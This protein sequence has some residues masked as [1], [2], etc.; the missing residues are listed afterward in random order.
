MKKLL[1]LLSLFLISM[2]ITA[3]NSPTSRS[4]AQQKLNAFAK[5]ENAEAIRIVRKEIIKIRVLLD[6]I[7]YMEK[8]GLAELEKMKQETAIYLY[9]EAEK[10]LAQAANEQQKQDVIQKRKKSLSDLKIGMARKAQDIRNLCQPERRKIIANIKDLEN[11]LNTFVARTKNYQ[12]PWNEQKAYANV[13]KEKIEDII[14]LRDRASEIHIIIDSAEVVKFNMF[15]ELEDYRTQELIKLEKNVKQDLAKVHSISERIAIIKNW[16]DDFAMLNKIVDEG[17][18]EFKDEITQGLDDAKKEEQNA[19]TKAQRLEKQVGIKMNGRR[20]SYH[21]QYIAESQR[22]Q[23]PT[24]TRQP[25][26]EKAQRQAVQKRRSQAQNTARTNNKNRS[27]YTANTRIPRKPIPQ[28]KFS[29]SDPCAAENKE[30]DGLPWD[31]KPL[32]PIEMPRGVSPT[33]PKPLPGIEELSKFDYNAAVSLA[34]ENMRLLYGPME[35]KDAKAFQANWAPLFD[36]PN[37]EI[38]DYLNKLNPMATQFLA[39]RQSYFETLSGI[40]M[41]TLDAGIAV[42]LKDKEVF[43]EIMSNVS[44]DSHRL[45]SLNAA[46][47]QLA[48]RISI[49][50]NPPNP[51]EARCEARRRYNKFFKQKNTI[52]SNRCYIV[53][54]A[55]EGKTFKSELPHRYVEYY[56]HIIIPKKGIDQMVRFYLVNGVLTNYTSKKANEA[57]ITSKGNLEMDFGES[58]L[59]TLL[60]QALEKGENSF[61]NHKYKFNIIQFNPED[62]PEFLGLSSEEY[63]SKKEEITK[64]LKKVEKQLAI[65]EK[66]YENRNAPPEMSERE[67]KA[68]EEK[69]KT[70]IGIPDPLSERPGQ[71]NKEPE[72]DYELKAELVELK[73][74]LSEQLEVLNHDY[75]EKETAKKFFKTMSMW[76]DAQ[77]FDDYIEEYEGDLQIDLDFGFDD[78]EDK[79]EEKNYKLNFSD[80]SELSQDV[81]AD[82][83]DV[84][85]FNNSKLKRKNQDKQSNV[86]QDAMAEQQAIQESIDF[87]YEL[88]DNFKNDYKWSAKHLAAE[89]L[90]LRNAKTALDRENS[91]R[92]IKD[93]QM[94][95]LGAEASMQAEL[96]LAHSLKTGKYVRTRTAFDDYCHN[97]MRE[98]IKKSMAEKEASFRYIDRIDKQIRLLP[99][100]ERVTARASADKIFDSKEFLSGDLRQIKA[101]TGAIGKK[102]AGHAEYDQAQAEEEIAELNLKEQAAQTAVMVAG[103]VAVGMGSAALAETFGS[104]T[105]MTVHGTK[106]LGTAYGATTGYISGG[107]REAFTQGANMFGPITGSVAAFVNGFYDAGQKKGATFLSQAWE[108]VCA[109]GMDFVIGKGFEFGVGVVAKN[110]HKVTKYFGKEGVL[111]KPLFQQSGQ[112]AKDVAQAMRTT[113]R[114]SEADDLFRAYSKV[115]NQLRTLQLGEVANADKIKQLMAK[116]NQLAALGNSDFHFKW[117]MKYKAN[118]RIRTSFDNSVQQNYSK[119]YGKMTDN[120]SAKGYDMGGIEFKQFRN[121]SSRGT[122]SMDLD[123]GPVSKHS[124]VEPKYFIKNGQKVDAR[125]FMRDAQNAM[126]SEYFDMYK[127]SAKTSDMNLVTSVHE[128]AFATVKL[129]DDNVD[130]SNLTSKEV[131]SISDVIGAKMNNIS[132]N[133]N[134]T[135]VAKLQAKCRE[136]QKEIENMLLKKLRQDLSRVKKGSAEYRQIQADI[137]YWSDINQTFGEIGKNENNPTRIINLNKKINRMTGGKDAYMV[138]D[139][140]M[141]AFQPTR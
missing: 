23:T 98:N 134:L 77:L 99:P 32:A 66:N 4:A 18:E 71:Q 128:E 102:V 103:T 137:T 37:K 64:K 62:F 115:D 121:P 26:R 106:A 68:I 67:R 93:Y 2:G 47:T 96:D 42:E 108:G 53:Y 65:W 81:L 60:T 85:G 13:S 27:V 19:I 131:S 78:D 1:L 119:M 20:L 50:G 33:I 112:R 132:K 101:L 58:G 90:K 135:K 126:N 59:S 110:A 80:N 118:P 45:T 44:R 30:Q 61:F 111:F 63:E 109:A 84:S 105:A 107:P 138:I 5:A 74:K 51:F 34:F 72:L 75:Y 104:G 140:L 10:R 43:E 91:I 113:Q 49:L 29:A 124:G 36:N 25:Q 116:K 38:I 141:K 22:R 76:E 46:M 88:A 35:E 92:A 17:I 120:L 52:S 40:Q 12:A 73:R 39:V 129:L 54:A 86:N 133:K 100:E 97:K 9:E 31:N 16:K 127:I 69:E 125:T 21:G 57:I 55:N 28:V 15:A 82:M 8:F 130:F 136:S 94:R 24:A 95:M 122:S 89:R 56:Y 87:H 117:R 48:N 83:G 79:K 11:E 3:Q 41:L 6:S 7:N 139:D 70:H 14:E 114:I 123:L